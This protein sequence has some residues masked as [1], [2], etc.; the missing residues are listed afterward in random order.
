MALVLAVTAALL[1]VTAVEVSVGGESRKSGTTPEPVIEE[2][3]EGRQAEPISVHVDGS[4]NQVQLNFRKITIPPKGSTGPHCHYG[5]LLGVV[6][7]GTLTLYAPIFSEGVHKYKA[8]ES[9]TEG[10]GYV[11]EG[12]NESD[13]EDVVLWV[14]YITPEGKPLAEADLSKCN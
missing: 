5:Q 7:K 10:R 11:H 14:T 4:G 3:A 6:Q 8:G 9:V 13:T 12:H 2:L 1:S